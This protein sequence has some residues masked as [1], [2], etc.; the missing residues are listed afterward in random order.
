MDRKEEA[1]AER[2]FHS[3][4]SSHLSKFWRDLQ[5]M[6][7]RSRLSIQQRG[8]VMRDCQI[9]QG[10]GRTVAARSWF[11]SDGFRFVKC[12]ICDG[13]GKSDYRPSPGYVASQNRL[14]EIFGIAS[15]STNG[16]RQ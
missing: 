10:T 1:K 2:K 9:C 8:E 13:S 6:H 16:E 14:R 4:C 12:G 7:R 11:T 5:K 3:Q 15:Q